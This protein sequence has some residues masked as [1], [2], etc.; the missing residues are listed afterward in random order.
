MKQWNDILCTTAFTII[1]SNEFEHGNGNEKE[2]Q[3]NTMPRT[4][5]KKHTKKIK[6]KK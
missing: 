2:H 3:T 4:R 6:N 1:D 5:K